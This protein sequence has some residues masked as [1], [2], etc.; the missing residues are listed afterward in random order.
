MVY[1]M[2]LLISMAPN[3]EQLLLRA[4]EG[5]L[6][7]YCR[8][9]QQLVICD[10]NSRNRAIARE[11]QINKIHSVLGGVK[12]R[13]TICFKD[14]TLRYQLVEHHEWAQLHHQKPSE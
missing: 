9:P 14:P 10:F 12:S 13:G 1:K 7:K 11:E 5:I 3:Y 8:N 6:E 4:D 2:I